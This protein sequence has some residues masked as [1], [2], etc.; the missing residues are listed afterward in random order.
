[1]RQ[2]VV[3]ID[4]CTPLPWHVLDDTNHA[5][6]RQ[7]VENCPPQRRHPRRI[8]SQCPVTNRCMRLGHA[9]VQQWQAID[10]DADLSQ[11]ESNRFGIAPRRLYRGH[12]CDV[13]KRIERSTSRKL[14][15]DR[16]THPGNAAPLLI[17]RNQNIVAAMQFAQAIRQRADLLAVFDIAFEQDIARR[18]DIAKQAFLVIGK[19]EAGQAED[20]RL[21][22]DR[23]KA[24]LWE[25]KSRA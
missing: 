3:G 10:I 18:L 11:Y 25:N 14:W 15:P 9:D 22:T 19:G 6:S 2:F 20:Y 23:L 21:H 16:T 5:A 13:V 1:M 17:D 7:P 12:R 4:N 24:R 8:A